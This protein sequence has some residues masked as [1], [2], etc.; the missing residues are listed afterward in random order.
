MNR[1]RLQ[2]THWRLAV[3]ALLALAIAG[4]AACSSP[5]GTRPGGA[6]GGGGYNNGAPRSSRRNCAQCGTVRAVKQVYVEKNSSTMGTV[7][8]ALIGG[9]LGN[10]VG[11][12]NGRTAATVAGA[13]A[14]G[15]VGHEVG[16]R[17][18]K[19]VPAWRVVVDLDNGQTVTV[20]QSEDPRVHRGDYVQVRNGHV[21]L[22]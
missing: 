15:A 2:R 21:Y 14:G 8:G 16:K 3:A 10:Q 4:L 12:G 6:Y 7:V 18:A 22:L 20:T 17:N 11:K 19:E 13:A 9:V 5:Y 1:T